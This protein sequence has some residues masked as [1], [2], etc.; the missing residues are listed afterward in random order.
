MKKIISLIAVFVFLFSASAA[1]DPITSYAEVQDKLLAAA[2]KVPKEDVIL[3]GVVASIVP[4][5]SNKNTYYLFVMV[6]DDDVSMW[7]TEDDNYFVTVLRSEDDPL[8]I[9]LDDIVTVE[10]RFIS[11]YSSPICPYIDPYKISKTGHK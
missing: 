2:Y 5:Y 8:P 4:S 11:I 9:V 1:A 6:N 7:S 10:G 3:S